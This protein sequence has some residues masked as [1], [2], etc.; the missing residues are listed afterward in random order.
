MGRRFIDC[1]E[2]PSDLKC[3]VAISADTDA[4]L[5]EAAVQHAMAVHGHKD[6]AELRAQIKSAFRDGT[7]PVQTPGHSLSGL[8]GTLK[9][10]TA[11]CPKLALAV[12]AAHGVAVHRCRLSFAVKE[13]SHFFQPRAGRKPADAVAGGFAREGARIG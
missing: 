5:L 10:R 2:M 3:S 7:P 6:T 1:R 11:G 12:R 8:P 4:E 9:R 13:E